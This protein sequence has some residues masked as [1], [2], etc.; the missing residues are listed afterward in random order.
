[1]LRDAD[2][3]EESLDQLLR[4]A[5]YLRRHFPDK[6]QMVAF[7]ITEARL[8]GGRL[9]DHTKGLTRESDRDLLDKGERILWLLAV[10]DVALPTRAAQLEAAVQDELD[11]VAR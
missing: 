2:A 1:V 6:R 7:A 9:E 11:P 4:A 5:R 3:Y 10:A 8:K